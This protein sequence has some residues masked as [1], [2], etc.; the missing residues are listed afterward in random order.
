MD[1]KIGT[2]NVTMRCRAEGGIVK[3]L[4]KEEKTTTP[5][6]GF[7][8]IGYHLRDTDTGKVE[9]SFRKPPYKTYSES[10]ETIRKLFTN[11]SKDQSKCGLNVNAI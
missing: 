4:K 8:M 3:K 10:V 7:N 5:V 9:E 1:I 2:T 6:Y 11:N